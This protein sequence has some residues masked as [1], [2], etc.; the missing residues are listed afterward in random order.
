MKK[1]ASESA[2]FTSRQTFHSGRW[3]FGRRREIH[4]ARW[5]WIWSRRLSSRG[6]AASPTPVAMNAK[7][8]EINFTRAF[9]GVATTREREKK[10]KRKNRKHARPPD[11]RPRD[12]IGRADQPIAASNRISELRLLVVVVIHACIHAHVAVHARDRVQRTVEA[13]RTFCSCNNFTMLSSDGGC[14]FLTRR[15]T[16]YPYDEK[17]ESQIEA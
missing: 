7:H 6:I 3:N 9:N 2:T 8:G 13:T 16:I 1:R 17:E 12:A 4:R 10:K 5:N 15:W 11:L 14:I